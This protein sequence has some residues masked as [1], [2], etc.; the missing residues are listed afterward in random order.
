MLKK[1]A[2]S[3]LAS[4]RPSTYPRGYASALHSL[5]PCW[6]AF[7]SILQECSP[8]G[9]TCGPSKSSRAVIIVPQPAK[10]AALHRTGEAL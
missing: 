1:S 3:V 9:H 2:S 4:F 6:T 8:I 7:L 10:Q 5:R